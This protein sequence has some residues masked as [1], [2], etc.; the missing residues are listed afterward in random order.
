MRVTLFGASGLLG[1]ALARELRDEQ[2][3]FLSSTDADIR[4]SS[5]IHEVVRS[6]KPDWIVLAAAYTDVDGCESNRDLAFAVNCDGALHVAH[7]AL[8][9][10]AR[11]MFVSTDYVF[12]GAKK[13]PY[14]AQD[15]R[16]PINVY[17][18]TK[19]RAEEQLIDISPE[20][21]VVRTSWLFGSGGKCFPATIL[22]LAETRSELSVVNDQRGSPTCTAD[23]AKAM[24]ELCRAGAHGIVHCTNAGDC[25]WFV[26]AKAI[27]DGAGFST[28]IRPVTTDKFPRPARRPEYSVLSPDSLHAFGVEMRPWQDALRR[29]LAERTARI[30]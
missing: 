8:E 28:A 27:V 12:D 22:K 1:Q 15:A 26:F 6:M 20:I 14:E 23:L 24:L 4:D 29:Y 7:A 16:N 13:S 17:G 30:Y 21:C 10:G 11:M 3:T 2:L 25:T 18:E 9:V 19:S 5:R